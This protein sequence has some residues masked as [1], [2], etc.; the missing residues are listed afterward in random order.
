MDLITILITVAIMAVLGGLF[1]LALAFA[2]K[3]FEVKKDERIEKIIDALP[4]ANCGG[5]GYVGC[6]EYAN[7]VVNNSAEINL[8]SV[9]GDETVDTLSIIMGVYAEKKQRMHAQILCS[10]NYD[11]TKVKYDYAGL[12]DCVSVL[13][14]G[15]GPKECPYGC[16]GLGTCAHVCPFDAIKIENGVAQVEYEKC[17]A[18]GICV[19]SCPQN[20]IKMVPFNSDV[21]VGCSSKDRGVVI[22]EYCDVGCIGCGICKKVCP[23]EAIEFSDNIAYIDYSKCTNCGICV[24][25]CPRNIIR[26]EKGHN[27]QEDN[28]INNG[29]IGENGDI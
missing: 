16:I 28:Y 24:E 15:N 13:K 21:R 4:G 5:C 2:G 23:E 25:K 10:G 18:C 27:N 14:L 20:I 11:C 8:C 19:N 22:R 1:G 3:V 12:N 6:E 26:S 17:R 7:A 29:V 9:G